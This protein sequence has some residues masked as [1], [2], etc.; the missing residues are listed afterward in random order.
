MLYYI[1]ITSLLSY[2]K[3]KR[4]DQEKMFLYL[5]KIMNTSYSFFKASYSFLLLPRIIIGNYIFIYI[6][7]FNICLFY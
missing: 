4:F 6:Y 5:T 3:A 2:V 1:I 7:F